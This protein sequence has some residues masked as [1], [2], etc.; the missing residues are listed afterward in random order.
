MDYQ[1]FV[2]RINDKTYVWPNE[3]TLTI[4][5]QEW[6]EDVFEALESKA[7]FVKNH[8]GFPNII[9]AKIVDGE[10]VC[11]MEDLGGVR[12]EFNYGTV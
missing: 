1:E 6:P 9:A 12:Y 8:G 4:I 2:E 5:K 11:Q 3:E 7:R 10:L